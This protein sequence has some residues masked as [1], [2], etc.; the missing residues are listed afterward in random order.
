MRHPVRG[1]RYLHTCRGNLRSTELG[2]G[3]T[4]DVRVTGAPHN[5][6]A[7]SL[8]NEQERHDGSSVSSNHH[9]APEHWGAASIMN[10]TLSITMLHVGASLPLSS[11]GY[12]SKLSYHCT[13][14]P[15]KKAHDPQ[16]V[17]NEASYSA[18]LLP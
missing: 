11:T 10:A 15:I 17:A 12:V 5:K 13:A 8:T 9:I 4:R 2:L 18:P 7:T 14:L 1:A 16:K 3:C 6:R